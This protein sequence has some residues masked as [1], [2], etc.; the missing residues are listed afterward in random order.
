MVNPEVELFKW[1][2]IDS[3]LLPLAYTMVPSFDVMHKLFGICWPESLVIYDRDKAIW[4]IEDQKVAA[5]SREFTEKIILEENQR[6][7]YYKVWNQNVE[8]LN[9]IQ[10]QIENLN[11]NKLTNKKL[12]ETFKNWGQA[13]LG[14]WA[15]GMTAEL[16][17]YGLEEKVK[18]LLRPYFTD[19][20]DLNEAFATLATPTEISFY[21]EEEADL[22]SIAL[23]SGNQKE[24][25]LEAHANQFFWI[26]NNYFEAKILDK[27]YFADQIKHIKPND[28][29]EFLK[30]VNNYKTKVKQGIAKY[31]SELKLN[32]KQIKLIELLDQAIIFQ[33]VRKKYN[34]IATH[35]LE[36]FLKE[37]S[38]RYDISVRDLKWLL[39]EEI[40]KVA[41]G[42]DLRDLIE[43]R[44]HITTA[45]CSLGKLEISIQN[46]AS[47]I[48]Q[49]FNKAEFEKSVN[50]QGTVACTST[51]RYFR[52][53]AKV[54]L[55]PREG[56]KLQKD[57]ILVTTMTTPDYVAIIKR[58]GAIITDIG[59][60]TCH[61]AVVA[62]E[63][64]IPCIV[65]TGNATKS[66]KDG[67]ILE[68]HNLRGTVKITST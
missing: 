14:F 17:N 21:K 55:S 2:P 39:P 41:N 67:D 1:G 51:N 5:T 19:E 52:G 27:K 48:N 61:A 24:K 64:G 22:M 45:L 10:R 20:R 9:K 58:S 59:G 16:V 37:L 62:R 49:E 11:L 60:V 63:F 35:Y 25:A 42:E 47:K 56:E 15:V 43:K 8:I 65:G 44:K 6:D 32:K 57:E 3:A 66:I 23:L 53:I 7:Q 30:E 46:K 54:V 31:I 34:L 40:E 18:N 29:K 33:D 4:I 13:Y 28:T 38:K 12:E 36:Q 68:L 26:Y 50:L